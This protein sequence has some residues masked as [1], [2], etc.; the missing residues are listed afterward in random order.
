LL[1]TDIKIG[2][3]LPGIVV[4]ALPDYD[5]SL[6]LIAGSD[7]LAQ[8]PKKFSNKQYKVGDGIVAA[9]F[10]MK[11]NKII[12]SQ[13]SPHYYRRIA[14]LA[15]SDLIV[16][17]LI[18]VKRVA[19][20]EKGKFVKIAVQKLNGVDPIGE[21]ISHLG[22]VKKYTDD[23]F[24]IVEYCEDMKQYIKNSLRPAPSDKIYTV[25][26]LHK[27]REAIVKVAPEYF[28]YFLGREG[29]NVSAAAKLLG[30]TIRIKK[31]PG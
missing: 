8:L 19:S 18:K 28:G 6:V 13:K 7:H 29:A 24:T 12:L 27:L 26:Y 9:V 31:V 23:T 10:Q 30:I 17:G 21:C 3:L 25:T 5:A 20:V 15:F 16:R 4:K 22:N 11:E 14:E 1:T 2:Y